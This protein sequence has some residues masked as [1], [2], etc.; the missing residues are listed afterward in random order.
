MKLTNS[1]LKQI[2]QEEMAKPLQELKNEK[3]HYSLR[4][5]TLHAKQL[6]ARIEAL[7]VRLKKAGL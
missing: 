1:K 5:F 3:V 4:D 6:Y 7:E 2:I